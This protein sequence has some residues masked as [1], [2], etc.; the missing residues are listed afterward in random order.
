MLLQYQSPLTFSHEV[1]HNLIEQLNIYGT[2]VD[3]FR[4]ILKL[5]VIEYVQSSKYM[6][7]ILSNEHFNKLGQ[8][9]EE[10]KSRPEEF[11]K[12]VH[13]IVN[14]PEKNEKRRVVSEMMDY[15]EKKRKWYK[16]LEILVEMV[17]RANDETLTSLKE[18][19]TFRH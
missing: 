4:R 11:V 15:I 14:I 13:D 19:N 6:A 8:K 16:A 1:I 3:K 9:A 18:K 2:S 5:L 7:Q 10:L 17:T 12:F